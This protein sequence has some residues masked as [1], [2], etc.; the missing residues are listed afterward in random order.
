M[1]LS[2][3]MT[4]SWTDGGNSISGTITREPG[5]ELVINETIPESSTDLQFNCAIDV[6]QM[7]NY[8]LLA[9]GGNMTLETNS[10]SA[11]AATISLVD[12][13]PLVW[14]STGGYPSVANQA[15]GSTDVTSIFVTSVDGGTLKIYVGTDPTP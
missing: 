13:I 3:R 5:L 7:T 10:S 12:G 14:N 15:F 6:S 1:A 9:D 8:I 11:P 2:T 4:L